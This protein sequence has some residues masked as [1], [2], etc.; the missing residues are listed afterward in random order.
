MKGRG[1]FKRK[2]QDPRKARIFSIL[3]RFINDLC[4]FSNN[5]FENNYSD[6]YPD[7]LELKK[8]NKDFCKSSLKSMKRNLPLR[9]LIKK[10]PFPFISITC[11]VWIA[12]YQ[13]KHFISQSVLKFYVFP[14]Q[15]KT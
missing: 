3:F 2:K 5:E 1:L 4:T 8:E 9:C 12:M 13:L 6:I 15:Q 7:E 11:R 14:R 10:M